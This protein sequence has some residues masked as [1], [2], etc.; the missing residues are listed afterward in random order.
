MIDKKYLLTT[1]QMASFVADGYLRFDKLIPD[2][3]NKAAHA[4]METGVSVRGGGGT[5][6]NDVWNDGSA[7]GKVFGLPEVQGIVQSL[8]GEAPLYDHH[9]VHI[10][11]P[12]NEVGQIWHADAIIDLRMHFDIQF[13][14]FSHDTPREMGGTMILPGS[15]YRRVCETDI[16]RYQNFLGQLPIAC[17]AGTLFVVHHGMW[18]CAQPNLTEDTRY[19]FKLRLNPTVRQC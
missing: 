16:A 4:E 5:V 10:V 2:E 3:L 9:A 14:Y 7:V 1:E 15:H 13:F 11:R 6:L 8:V 17:E 12:Q 18:H 19:M